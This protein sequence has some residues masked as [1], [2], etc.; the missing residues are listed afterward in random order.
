MNDNQKPAVIKSGEVF[1]ETY[2]VDEN[3]S[4]EPAIHIS[5][6]TFSLCEA[7]FLRLKVGTPKTGGW[8]AAVFIASVGMALVPFAKFLQTKFLGTSVIIETWEWVAP[9]IGAVIALILYLIGKGLSNERK[10]VMK[11]IENHFSKAPRTKHLGERR[12]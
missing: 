9:C 4:T 3:V 11:D 12:K 7:D 10:Q 1:T 5:Q 8:S 2:S 6:E